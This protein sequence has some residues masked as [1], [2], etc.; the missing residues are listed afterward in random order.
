MVMEAWFATASCSSHPYYLPK[1]VPNCGTAGCIAGWTL[2]L[3]LKK[4]LRETDNILYAK[5]VDYAD[6]VPTKAARLLGLRE[7]DTNTL[8]L[9]DHWPNEIRRAYE[10]TNPQT[11]A[12]ARLIARRI[13]QFIEEQR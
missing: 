13:D 6:Y 9:P 5:A 12:R 3:A 1:P 11:K 4:T 7:A 2:A 10:R 8:F